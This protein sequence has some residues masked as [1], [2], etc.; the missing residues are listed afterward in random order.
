MGIAEVK[1]RQSTCQEGE[2]DEDTWQKDT[3]DNHIC[4]AT[5]HRMVD[6]HN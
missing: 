2:A 1:P 4:N 6:D 5:V 3:A